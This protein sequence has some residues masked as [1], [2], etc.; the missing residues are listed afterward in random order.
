MYSP[1]PMDGFSPPP[2]SD[3]SPIRDF[4]PPINGFPSDEDEDD[5]VDQDLDFDF[6]MNDAQFD[7]TG[8]SDKLNSLE[9]DKISNLPPREILELKKQ[10]TEVNS[11]Y[12]TKVLENNDIIED[13]ILPTEELQEN[14]ITNENNLEE[15]GIDSSVSSISDDKQWNDNPVVINHIKENI[16]SEDCDNHEDVIEKNAQSCE[17]DYEQSE[18]ECVDDSDIEL[19]HRNIEQLDNREDHTEQVEDIEDISNVC[20]FMEDGNGNDD[21]GDWSNFESVNNVPESN[22]WTKQSVNENDV[23]IVES[24]SRGLEF[25][26]SDDDDFGDF[27]EAETRAVPREP[28]QSTSSSILNSLESIA[29][30]SETIVSS[31]LTYSVSSQNCDEYDSLQLESIVMKDE[32]IFEKIEDPASSPALDHQWK[33]SSTY[34]LIMATLGIDSRILLD[35]ENW[36]N[37]M[38]K[39]IPKNAASLMTPGLL[40]PEPAS[41]GDNLKDCQDDADEKVV[42]SE[43]VIPAQFD[44]NKSGLTNPLAENGVHLSLL[45]IEFFANASLDTNKNRPQHSKF[46]YKLC[47]LAHFI[48]FSVVK[49]P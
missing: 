4:P 25:D 16:H 3:L 28:Q 2:M 40:T 12:S 10:S 22:D 19:D 24:D 36:R 39:Y 35:G 38:P 29:N 14:E 34:N 37:S 20:N 41:N 9:L 49:A 45:D 31:L 6:A 15:N 32:T 26:E 17:N 30:E 11:F 1:P 43:G 44:W 5:L 8:L 27:G 23:Q 47:Y 33:D 13:S 7:V 18:T 21:N 42:N 48:Y 46:T